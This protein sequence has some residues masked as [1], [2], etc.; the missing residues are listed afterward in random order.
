MRFTPSLLLVCFFC[1]VLAVGCT[2]TPDTG[3]TAPPEPVPGQKH[4]EAKTGKNK[5]GLDL[6]L[7]PPP[8]Q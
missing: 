1:A 6:P 2:K 4:P 3:A 5:P 7:P 8:P